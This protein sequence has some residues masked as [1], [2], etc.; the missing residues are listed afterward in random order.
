MAIET[1]EA[2][3]PNTEI[4]HPGSR[5]L[6]R[7]WEGI[8]GECA[9]PSRDSIDLKALKDLVPW[10]FVLERNW[11]RKIFS[12]RL[13]GT[14]VCQ[15]W[16][17]ELTGT[18]VMKGWDRFELDT[19]FRLLDGVTTNLQP[20]A[21]RLR[22]I[23]SLGHHLPVEMIALPIRARGNI[24][25]HIFGAITPFLDLSALGYDSIVAIHLLSARVIWTEPVPGDSL[26][27]EKIRKRWF[28]PFQVITGGRNS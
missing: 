26:I 20:C 25:T 2:T 7:Y 13:A 17:A 22:L 12:W 6:F 19:A 15:L 5:K 11:T 28:S 18:D 10:L 3:E 27:D 9:A 16:R 1:I 21:F 23:T 24:A 4:L 8:R 14:G